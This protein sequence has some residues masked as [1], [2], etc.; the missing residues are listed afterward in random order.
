MIPLGALG[1]PRLIHQ[2]SDLVRYEDGQALGEE[3][4][5][6]CSGQRRAYE[7]QLRPARQ[8]LLSLTDDL[9]SH[10]LDS[11]RPKPTHLLPDPP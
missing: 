10:D 1:L 6:A 7:R 8:L 9:D 3:R 4:P 11:T 5:G 2:L